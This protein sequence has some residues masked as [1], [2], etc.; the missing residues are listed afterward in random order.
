M[1]TYTF[2]GN[3]KTQFVEWN[4]P[5]VWAGGVVPNSPTADVVFPEI[6]SSGSIYFSFVT[7]GSS[8]SFTANSVSITDN[9]LELGGTLSVTN[10]V[11]IKAGGELN[12]QGG[13]LSAGS[14]AVESAVEPGNGSIQGNGQI[15]VTGTVTND[16]QIIGSGRSIS[17]AA[18][19]NV[20]SLIATGN[21]T[22]TVNSGGFSN[23]SGSTLTGGTYVATGVLDLNVGAVIT[24]DA[25][26]IQLN[27]GG[28]IQSFD[29]G[30]SSYV[31]LQTSLTTIAQGG[32][33]T[34]N[35]QTFNSNGLTDDGVLNLSDSGSSTTTFNAPLLTIGSH[36]SVNG[37]GTIAAPVSNSGTI[38]VGFMPGDI[39]IPA[40]TSL[41]QNNLLEITGAVSGNGALEIAAPYAI[42]NGRTNTF[43]SATLQLDGPDSENVI[44]SS[45]SI[46]NNSPNNG[47]GTLILNDLAG[48]TGAIEPESNGDNIIL[49]NMSFSSVT[50][51]SYSGSTAGGTLTIHETGNVTIKLNFVGD[52]D[53]ADFTLAAGPQPLSSSPPSLEITVN[54]TP[55]PSFP[56]PN[57]AAPAGTTA[58]LV[59]N[60]P[61]NG[62]YEI[63]DMGNNSGLAA[64]PLATIGTPWQ[65]VG[66]GNF[67]GH[68]TSDMLLRNMTAGSFEIVD[69]S[70]NNASAPILLGN[71][72]LEWQV[73][74]FG[75]FSGRP[76]ET[77]M[78]MRDSQNG[79]FELYDFSNN[80]VPF[81]GALSGI[82]PNA[83]VLGFGDFSGKANETD[84]LTRDS[85][86]SVVLY[87]ISNNTVTSSTTLG[88]LGFEWQFAAAG[89][90]SSRPG[91]TDL[92]MRDSQNGNFELYDFQNGQVTA[93]IALGNVGLEWQVAGVADF[94]GKPN[95]TDLLMR[96]TQN[97]NFE[98]YDFSNNGVTAAVALG[99]VGLEWQVVGTAPFQ[100]TGGAT[101]ASDQT[102]SQSASSAASDPLGASDWLRQTMQTSGGGNQP[103]AGLGFSGDAIPMAGAMPDTSLAMPNPLQSHTA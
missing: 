14:L 17:A 60:N 93:A 86:Q 99:N 66:L 22:V 9:V 65:T 64:Y 67:S 74:G 101:P 2:I 10:A 102:L 58:V 72:G 8:E 87:D 36:G 15:N 34:L 21:L 32:T 37:V 71:V 33:L 41:P 25:A 61:S 83:T 79:A 48:F 3:A 39:V 88:N 94:S 50:G 92:L 56:P 91:E 5:T 75:D 95:E 90:F 40:L 63:Y 44:F 53:T 18:F 29:A 23:L 84:L 69:V 96:D 46:P 6:T 4:D 1:T 45:F 70:N 57:P 51:Y 98:L 20:G 55:S 13:T 76:G 81:A 27:N 42:Q 100:A 43:T 38:T 82:N 85:S 19:G 59:L 103:A 35:N 26:N 97:G 31:S 11:D 24:T 12:Q 49:P 16:G 7:I 54:P 52:L 89:D 30:S 62:N 78:L 73:A 28:N 68:G 47:A 80:S 77:D